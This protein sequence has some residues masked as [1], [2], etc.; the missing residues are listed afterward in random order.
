MARVVKTPKERNV[1]IRLLADTLTWQ[2]RGE[3]VLV[4]GRARA[5]LWIGPC[6]GHATVY[7]VS[8]VV[9]LRKLAQAILMELP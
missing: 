9:A 4:P 8:G 1:R 5:Y 6:E 3:V 2:P 7:T